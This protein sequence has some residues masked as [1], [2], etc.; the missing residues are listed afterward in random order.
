MK[1]VSGDFN[2]W[3]TRF[4]DQIETCETIG[5]ELS[6]EAKILYFMNNLNDSIF[7]DVKAN[8]MDL[9]TRALFPQTYEEIKQRMIAEYSQISTRKPQTVFK[10]LRGDDTRRYGEASFKAEEDGCH[11]CGIPGHFYRTCK[12]FNKKYSLEQN[13]RY[14]KR[15]STESSQ[16]TT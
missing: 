8:F 12:F 14:Y 13:Q 7:G 16:T 15:R 4:E 3:I 10:V 9:S 1:H 6:E 11:I 5:V 2:R